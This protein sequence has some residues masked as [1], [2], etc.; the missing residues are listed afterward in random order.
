VVLDRR[1]DF[2][3]ASSLIAD[4]NGLAI[5][6]SDEPGGTAVLAKATL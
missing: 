2:I 4:R 1:A 5:L 6:D 3:I